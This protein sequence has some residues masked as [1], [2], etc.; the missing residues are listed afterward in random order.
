MPIVGLPVGAESPG[1]RSKAKLR[2]ATAAPKI[3]EKTDGTMPA[4]QGS[5]SRLSLLVGIL[6]LFLVHFLKGLLRFN[7][8]LLRLIGF[9]AFFVTAAPAEENGKSHDDD[10]SFHNTPPGLFGFNGTFDN[11]DFFI[12]QAVELIHKLV[13]STVRGIDLALK[14][15]FF[16]LT[17]DYGKVSVKVKKSFD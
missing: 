12:G 1:D 4:P 17:L 3:P 8:R 11:F 14:D 9:S 15:G 16:L 10:D 7:L 5:L 6:L 13:D 2:I